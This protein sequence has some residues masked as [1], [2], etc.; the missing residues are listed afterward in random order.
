[1]SSLRPRFL[2]AVT[3]VLLATA[4]PGHAD[5][6][7]LAAKVKALGKK[8]SRL[9]ACQAKVAA[10]GN[11]SGLAACEEKA[12]DR[13]FVAMSTTGTCNEPGMPTPCEADINCCEGVADRCESSV[14]DTF[15]DTFPSGCEAAKRKAAGNLAGRELR[16]YATAAKR[17]RAVDSVCIARAQGKFTA[18]IAGAGPCPDGGSPQVL[19]EDS[20]VGPAVE[21]DSGGVVTAACPSTTTTSTTVT[22]TTTMPHQPCGTPPACGG[23]CPVGQTCVPPPPNAS[24]P[25]CFCFDQGGCTASWPACD[26]T[27]SSGGTC[28]PFG[29]GVCACVN[30]NCPCGGSCPAPEYWCFDS[31]SRLGCGC[32]SFQ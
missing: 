15:V 1:M 31:G 29:D 14:A 11:S 16:C 3:L 18:A 6:C 20:C 32:L 26:G 9:L 25:E 12:S 7:N 23:P 21:T 8:E 17:N 19:V 5:E 27:C 10:T 2:G 24:D 13:F 4:G 28:A 30:G 22:T